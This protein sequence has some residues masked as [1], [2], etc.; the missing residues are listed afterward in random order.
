MTQGLGVG[1]SILRKSLVVGSAALQRRML[2]TLELNNKDKSYEWLL[3]WL[4][5]H[6]PSPSLNPLTRRLTSTLTRS[7]NLS[8]ETSLQTHPNGSSSA[9][10]RLVAGPGTHYIHYAGHWMRLSRERDARAQALMS[11]QPW[12][13][14]TLTALSP[15]RAVF[16]LLLADARDAAMKGQEGRLVVHT[17]WGTEWRPF[18]L[19]RAKRPLKSV[20]L[21]PGVAEGI[22]R[23]LRTFLSRRE[24]YADR[25]IPYRRGYLL[26]GP[27]GSGK[28]SFI[29]SL[30]GELSYDIC[31]LNLSERGLTDDKLFHLLA[32]APERSFVL[33][34]DVDAAFNR[35][36]QTTEDGYQSSIT[37]S[38]LLNALDGVASS[39]S[40]RLVFMTTNHFARLD[41][42]L[43]RPGRV[44]MGVLIDDAVPAQACVLFERFY[45]AG[46]GSGSTSSATTSPSTPSTESPPP[47]S[48]DLDLDIA[49]LSKSLAHTIQ[50]EM[51]AGRRV[52]MA[53]LQGFFILHA[54][55]PRGAVEGVG[56]LFR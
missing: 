38:G 10:F 43:V 45:G 47:T 23:D 6:P 4:A 13:T 36:A 12:E 3:A 32:N 20:V 27:P 40:A 51:D 37:F 17:A 14:L 2:V 22:E 34:E 35:R 44:D 52:S 19:P 33:I 15:A 49:S 50:S 9:A 53:A 5:H 1:L 18:G 26:H 39:A 11:G 46:A 29:Q 8:V 41:P 28:T 31:V 56:G 55:D 25:G 48:P 30:A 16:P 24:W 42:A 54:E 21:A 7:H